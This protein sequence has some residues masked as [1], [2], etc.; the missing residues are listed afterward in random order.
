M[1][2]EIWGYTSQIKVISL[3][4]IPILSSPKYMSVMTYKSL[5]FPNT[6]SM[7]VSFFRKVL[8]CLIL[9]ESHMALVLERA[10]ALVGPMLRSECSFV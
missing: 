1:N 7:I 2:V 6:F 5:I 3:S 4:Q 8:A 9:H 10:P